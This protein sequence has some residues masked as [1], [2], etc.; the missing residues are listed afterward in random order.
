V[1]R[2]PLR[3]SGL[4]GTGQ[5][6]SGNDLSQNNTQTLYGIR[7]DGTLSGK[8]TISAN[9]LAQS[10]GSQVTTSTDTD[11]NT[12]TYYTVSNN[13]HLHHFCLLRCKQLSAHGCNGWYLPMTATGFTNAGW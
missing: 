1:T 9:L 4:F 13:D 12:L 11:G 8:T 5:Y 10:I 3:L 6:L 2:D 7:D